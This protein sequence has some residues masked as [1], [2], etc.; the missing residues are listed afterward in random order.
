MKRHSKALARV[1]AVLALGAAIV[2]LIVVVSDSLGGGDSKPRHNQVGSKREPN[3]GEGKDP[4][5]PPPKSYVVQPGDTLSSIAHKT[6]VS[7]SGIE[8][9]NPGVDPQILLAGD[10]LKLR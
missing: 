2:A 1:L 4:K 5:G 10:K 9:L 6:G 8:R 7:I 3:P